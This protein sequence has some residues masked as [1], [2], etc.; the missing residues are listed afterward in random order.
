MTTHRPVA[1]SRTPGGILNRGC[2]R[3]RAPPQVHKSHYLSNRL[4]CVHGGLVRQHPCCRWLRP[5]TSVVVVPTPAALSTP[6]PAFRPASC[7]R[8]G[9][10]AAGHHWNADFN[11]QDQPHSTGRFENDGSCLD[12]LRHGPT[13]LSPFCTYFHDCFKPRLWRGRFNNNSMVETFFR[14]HVLMALTVMMTMGH[15]S[16]C[17]TKQQTIGVD[18]R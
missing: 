9:R 1:Q 17:L 14:M 15:A 11:A 16:T 10:D 4:S 18:M 3:R 6:V 13:T 12:G 5:S 2:C 7:P 8:N